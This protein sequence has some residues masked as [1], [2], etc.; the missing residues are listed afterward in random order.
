MK[1]KCVDRLLY[2][3]SHPK[4]SVVW[5]VP[6]GSKGV[7]AVFKPFQIFAYQSFKG[8]LDA[9]NYANEQA[10]KEKINASIS[11]TATC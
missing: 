5:I 3:S 1:H 7:W 9:L 2:C 11:R 6:F 10:R 8:Y 4:W